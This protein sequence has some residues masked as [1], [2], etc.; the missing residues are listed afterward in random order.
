M[1]QQTTIQLT[2]KSILLGLYVFDANRRVNIFDVVAAVVRSAFMFM[3][4][5]L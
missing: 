5:E 1:Y 4:I 2:V 3:I